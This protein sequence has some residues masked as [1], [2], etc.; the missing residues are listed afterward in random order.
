M[1]VVF[2]LF[3]DTYYGISHVFAVGGF[4]VDKL[5]RLLF[6][7]VRLARTFEV[8]TLFNGCRITAQNIANNIG[9]TWDLC[10][11]EANRCWLLADLR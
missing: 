7:E 4:M 10:D 3:T 8:F 2:I 6:R 5:A 9:L 11:Q 1:S